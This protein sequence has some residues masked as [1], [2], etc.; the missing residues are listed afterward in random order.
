[1]Y[2]K[3]LVCGSD[4]TALH[5]PPPPSPQYLA[6]YGLDLSIVGATVSTCGHCIRSLSGTLNTVGHPVLQHGTV[7]LVRLAT[8]IPRSTTVLPEHHHRVLFR[9]S[10]GI[11]LVNGS[12]HGHRVNGRLTITRLLLNGLGTLIRRGDI[13]NRTMV[14]LRHTSRVKKQ[15]LYNHTGILRFR[16]LHTIITS[17]IDDTLRFTIQLTRQLVSQIR[18]LLRVDRGFRNDAILTRS[19]L[20]FVSRRNM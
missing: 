16:R 2:G 11:H 5:P 9:R 3:S 4:A 6:D 14:L 20:L 15:R 18:T 1:M 10:L 12:H 8:S 13:Q 19:I 17:M 7:T